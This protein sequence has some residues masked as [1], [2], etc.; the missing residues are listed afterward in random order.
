MRLIFTLAVSLL[1]LG[2]C[3]RDAY[4]PRTVTAPGAGGDATPAPPVSESGGGILGSLDRAGALQAKIMAGNPTYE[5]ASVRRPADDDLIYYG[6]R[7]GDHPSFHLTEEQQA[8]CRT[9]RSEWVRNYI[10]R[11]YS[12]KFNYAPSNAINRE[13]AE[14]NDIVERLAA[15]G[16]SPEACRVPECYSVP[17]SGWWEPHCG[18]RVPDP[19]GE[20][21][22]AWV[23]WRDGVEPPSLY[24]LA[25][26]KEEEVKANLRGCPTCTGR[27]LRVFSDQ[28]Q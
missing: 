19:T 7:V 28:T 20:E 14:V 8:A 24:A 26:R 18:Y 6:R 21:L 13:Q 3:A 12:H 1:V 2:A 16:L 10:G 25:R 23:E 11:M 15:A 17:H 4:T 9:F 22:Y 27:H 5:T